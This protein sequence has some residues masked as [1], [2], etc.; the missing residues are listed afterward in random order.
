MLRIFQSKDMQG[1]VRGDLMQRQSAQDKDAFRIAEKIIHRVEKEG[2]SA[3]V[4][5]TLEF[6]KVRLDS[7]L[8]KPQE[9]DAAEK[10][11]SPELK[12][13]FSQAAENISA[14]HRLQRSGF[15]DREINIAGAKLGYRY[16]PLHGS[17]IYVPG[18]KAAYPS[19]VLMG[20]IPA[21][22]AGVQDSILITPPDSS[23]SVDPAVLF[24]AR[25]AGA[26]RVLKAGGAQGIAAA[27]FG[28]AGPPAVMIAGPGNRYVVAAKS[29]LAA[30][31]LIRMDMPAGP[32]EVLIIA[33]RS[34]NPVYVAADLLSQAEHGSDSQAILVTDDSE[35]A[36]AV[37]A[38]IER[39]LASR[40]GRRELKTASIRDHSYAIVFPR[41]SEA[42]EFANEYA[43]EHVEICTSNPQSDLDKI[44][45]AG[46]VFLGHYAPVA[47][48]DYFSGT[49]HVLPTGGAAR[50]YSG[51]GVDSFLKRIT[52][53]YP[54]KESL[55]AA[56][57]PIMLMSKHEGFDQEHGNSVAVRFEN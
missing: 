51:L 6:D 2:I 25:L 28:L 10:K 13:A 53:Q 29:I 32:S 38:E 44:T 48:G 3:V 19:S 55:K 46:S 52:H 21:V 42:F 56:L 8:V 54:T 5:Y 31:G 15:E 30:R 45:S 40:P 22:I 35:L 9:F 17:G 37:A 16:I 50:F 43:S 11:I 18:G 24:C 49:N 41:I 1:K 57:D 14:F 39:G 36:A 34:A 4:E 26:S 47:L 27:V 20:M 7:L 33:D 12:K 23:G